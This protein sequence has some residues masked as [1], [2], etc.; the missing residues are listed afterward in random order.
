[1]LKLQIYMPTSHHHVSTHHQNP[2]TRFS[3][4]HPQ[5]QVQ[6]EFLEDDDSMKVEE[7]FNNYVPR[8]CELG[9]EVCFC[10][11]LLRKNKLGFVP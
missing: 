2:P 9:N 7:V 1:M 3:N 6:D 5:Q 4:P 11:D 10:F 8:K